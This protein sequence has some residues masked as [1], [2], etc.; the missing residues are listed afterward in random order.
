MPG[1]A[2]T[3]APTSAAVS[4]AATRPG[5]TTTWPS[6]R[7]CAAVYLELTEVN[8]GLAG[9]LAPLLLGSAGAGYLSS[10]GGGAAAGGAAGGTAGAAG[11]AAGWRG[12]LRL[13]GGPGLRD[14]PPRPHRRRRPGGGGHGRRRGLRCRAIRGHGAAD[15]GSP[16][17]LNHAPSDPSTQTGDQPDPNP[18]KAPEAGRSPNVVLSSTP[19]TPSTGPSSDPSTGPSDGPSDGPSNSPSEPT[20]PTTGS[21]DPTTGPTD[22]TTGPTDPGGG[23]V[24]FTST[25]PADPVFG[26]TYDVSAS[27]RRVVFS[28]DPA[29]TNNAC[30]LTDRTVTFHHA[31]DC[32]IAADQGPARAVTHSTQTIPVPKGRQLITFSLPGSARSVTGFPCRRPAAGPA[33]RSRSPATTPAPSTRPAPGDHAARRRLHRDGPPAGRRRLHRRTRHAASLDVA[34]GD[35]RIDVTSNPP[36]SPAFEDTYDLTAT[37]TSGDPVTFSIDAQSSNAC[38]LGD[39]G[40]TVT[41]HH[42]GTCLIDADQAGDADY[43]PAPD[44]PEGRRAEGHPARHLRLDGADRTVV[45]HDLR[46]ERDQQLRRPGDLLRRRHHDARCLQPRPG[47]LDDHLPARGH[48]R[49]RRGP[50]RHRRLRRG[51]DGEPGDRGAEGRAVDHV[52]LDA[53]P[54]PVVRR[55][56][57]RQRDRRRLGQR[58][59]AQLRQPRRLH[60]RAAPR[61]PS[62][63]PAPA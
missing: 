47:R 19:A 33:T 51:A 43:L 28:I 37:S 53:A 45:R 39:D 14:G 24:S 5:S 12:Q 6:C 63:T 48:L 59:G 16:P 15:A 17:V 2:T 30:T 9:P 55:H 40:T 18:Q 46:G 23:D 20:E 11:G 29:T 44:H 42:A 54:G 26:S 32:V 58:R 8:S 31:G 38:T 62:G 34:K 4:P 3:S 49:D 35:Q 52:H 41:F 60:G 56:L 27:G 61:S 57:R 10:T 21:T 36:T 25:P 22:P 50:G 7:A 1:R 13:R